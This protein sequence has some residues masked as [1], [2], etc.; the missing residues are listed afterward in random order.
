MTDGL[1]NP[2]VVYQNKSVEPHFSESCQSKNCESTTLVMN[3]HHM[4]MFFRLSEHFGKY[5][6]FVFEERSLKYISPKCTYPHTC[7]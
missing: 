6:T 5:Y 1:G 4:N 7:S 2:I 3:I